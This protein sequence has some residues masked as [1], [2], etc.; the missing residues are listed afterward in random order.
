MAL[1]ALEAWEDGSTNPAKSVD[2]AVPTTPAEREIALWRAR[3][4]RKPL[5]IETDPEL[6]AFIR[7]RIRRFTFDT[8]VAEVAATFPPDRQTSRSGISRWWAKV[9]STYAT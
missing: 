6:E 8:I 1:Q 5:K 7:E 4:G 3:G 2:I 9:G